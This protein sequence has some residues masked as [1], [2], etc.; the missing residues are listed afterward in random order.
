MLLYLKKIGF[1]TYLIMSKNLFLCQFSAVYGGLQTCLT[2]TKLRIYQHKQI[3]HLS[4]PLKIEETFST[5]GAFE[6]P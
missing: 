3:I 2:F 1:G 5:W 6:K 4:A